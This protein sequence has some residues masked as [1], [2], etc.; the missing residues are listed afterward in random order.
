MTL[1]LIREFSKALGIKNKINMLG[2]WCKGTIKLDLD[3]KISRL[4]S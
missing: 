1:N 4:L 3:F 2:A